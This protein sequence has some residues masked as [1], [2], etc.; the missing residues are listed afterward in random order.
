MQIDAAFVVVAAPPLPLPLPL[1]L[2][3]LARIVVAAFNL[4]HSSNFTHQPRTASKA[5]RRQRQRRRSC[6]HRHCQRQRQWPQL[7]RAAAPVAF[8]Q[9]VRHEVAKENR[10]KNKRIEIHQEF[11]NRKIKKQKKNKK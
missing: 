8:C 7:S 4:L 11:K 10:K 5:T 3:P 9:R 1:A 6:R 2:L